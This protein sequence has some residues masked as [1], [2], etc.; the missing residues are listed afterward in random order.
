MGVVAVVLLG[1]R[2]AGA[3]GDVHAEPGN[4]RMLDLADHVA[5]LVDPVAVA[6]VLA[7]RTRLKRAGAL[8][9]GALHFRGAAER[10]RARQ[11][12]HEPGGQ[13]RKRRAKRALA[14][15]HEHDHDGER[16]REP[17]RTPVREQEGEQRERHGP[18]HPARQREAPH[19][20]REH[21][22]QEHQ[23]QPVRNRLV[24]GD[25]PAVDGEAG[26]ARDG[27]EP[28]DRLEG[29]QPRRGDEKAAHGGLVGQQV[30]DEEREQQQLPEAQ[31][32]RHE[33][34]RRRARVVA[35]GEPA[36]GRGRKRDDRQRHRP[37]AARVAALAHQV[38]PG[39]RDQD[40]EEQVRRG[41]TGPDRRIE[42]RPDRQ[43]ADGVRLHDD[44]DAEQGRE[45]EPR[46]AQ[47]EGDD[48]RSERQQ[49]RHRAEA[50]DHDD[51]EQPGQRPQQ[52]GDCPWE[53]DLAEPRPQLAAP[54]TRPVAWPSTA[55]PSASYE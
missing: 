24:V 23:H 1:Q 52:H 22:Q 28:R 50:V 37:D 32:R 3:P 10:G 33:P 27:Q 29:G 21:E 38:E 49:R 48:E 14:G 43:Q 40:V 34:A 45:R 42:A 2:I 31:P 4:R 12:E 20:R 18:P 19:A 39:P 47:Q 53:D 6:A 36:D 51:E 30:G 16:R 46:L 41:L 7:D 13:D 5:P 9:H 44:H 55:V 11:D 35:G 54:L 26:A 25:D 15:G 8:E 17:E